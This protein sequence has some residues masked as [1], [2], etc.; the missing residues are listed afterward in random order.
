MLVVYNDS[1]LGRQTYTKQKKV[2][3]SAGCGIFPSWHHLRKKQNEITTQVEN[4]PL[5]FT[6]VYFSLSEVVKLTISRLLESITSD[7][8]SS[9]NEYQIWF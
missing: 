5:P 3:G 2:L 4:L 8:P 6:G 9:T 7:I 1:K